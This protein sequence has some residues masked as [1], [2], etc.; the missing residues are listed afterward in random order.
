MPK[1]RLFRPPTL[2]SGLTHVTW[3]RLLG[4]RLSMHK[5]KVQPK[6]ATRNSVPITIIR[7]G[8]EVQPTR[9]QAP[10]VQRFTRVRAVALGIALIYGLLFGPWRKNLMQYPSV[11][12]KVM[13]VLYS[14]SAQLLLCHA[15]QRDGH[16]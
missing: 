11:T 4:N 9:G 12:V 8:G 5:K 15:P 16:H 13:M 14:V 3:V 6:I 10:G 7:K 2:S 1:I